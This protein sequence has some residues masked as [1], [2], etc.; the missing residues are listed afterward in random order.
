MRKTLI[1]LLILLSTAAKA[2][3]Y[4]V[5][6]NGNNANSGSQA[7]PWKTLAYACS[8]ATAA[9]DIIHIN[10]GTF[11][12][13]TQM[14]LAAGVSIEGAGAASS[15]IK[16][17]VTNSG[18]F[19]LMLHSS[20]E[21]TNGNQH[22]A[23]ITF[24]GSATTA[25]G[26]VSIMNR[27]NV[28]VYNCVF[29]DFLA[30]GIQ[31]NNGGTVPVTRATGNQFYNNTVTN[32][33]MYTTIGYG[34]LRIGGQEGMLVHDN[35]MSQ[36]GRASGKNGYVI[37]YGGEGWNRG[38]KIYNNTI[39]KEAYD[40]STFDF[41]IE[42]THEQGTEIYNNNIIG[43]LD[44]NFISKGTYS[45]GIYVHNNTFGPTAS[46]SRMENGIILE[47]DV[48]AAVIKNNYFRNIGSVVLFSTRS[49]YDLKN[50]TF[51]GNICDNIG[52]VG[53]P[54]GQCIRFI[55]VDSPATSSDGFYIYNNVI[56]ARPASSVPWGV[57]VPSGENSVN[58]V[59]RN[60]IIMNFVMGAVT[61]NPGS[62]VNGLTITNNILYNNGNGNNPFFA[63]GTPSGYTFSGNLNVDPKFVSASDFHLQST[64][65]AIGTGYNVS[66][67]T[68]YEGKAW[69]ATPSIGAYEYKSGTA[70]PAAP[71]YQS[72]SVENATPSVLEINY[73]LS[74]NSTSPAATAFTVLVNSAARSVSTVT[75]ASNKVQLTLSSPVKFGDMISVAYTQPSTNP[76]Q[77]TSGGIAAGY[78][79]KTVSNNL[80]SSTKDVIPLT[81]KITLSPNHVHKILNIQLEYSTSLT[82]QLLTSLTP[83]IVRIVDLNGTV[84]METLIASGS[85]SVKIPLNIT[86]GIYTVSIV[87]NGTEMVSQ[88]LV[89]Y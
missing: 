56:I 66:L 89:V 32:C 62:V 26:G 20:S 35:I 65:P 9:G 27:G 48:E 42:L 3:T 54:T 41:A 38:L 13:T 61:S 24:D 64:S 43:S 58:N 33:S 4:Y 84:Q 6:S 10:P 68:D 21:N 57:S 36:T 76:L 18:S 15:I 67:G 19:M 80:A 17:Q 88:K 60:N 53:S 12:E 52:I 14:N 72:S 46:R 11:T 28:Q 44:V 85:T 50:F 49:G 45:Y 73:D 39:T 74:L 37:K 47:F 31:F 78:T 59:I 55:V 30:T 34:G 40:G 75:I 86:S 70:A 22:I 83:E 25:Y 63:N 5:D 82:T 2:T 87:A 79:A 16:S 81:I 71:L 51:A 8:K 23:N 69:N 7:S 77:S 29:R 1:L